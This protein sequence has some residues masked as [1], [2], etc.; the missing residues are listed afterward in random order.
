MER[1]QHAAAQ[2]DDRRE[3]H[4]HRG[5]GNPQQSHAHKQRGDDGCRKDLKHA[6]EVK[7]EMTR[8]TDIND[9]H[10]TA[11]LKTIFYFALFWPMVDI[12]ASLALGLVIWYGGLSALGGG[13]TVGILIAFIQ[14]ARRFFEP[15]RVNRILTISLYDLSLAASRSGV[16]C[17][18]SNS[19]PPRLLGGRRGMG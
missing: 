15:I 18:E 7:E 10:R 1:A 12:V 2:E 5:H 14:Y 13:L 3:Q 11:Y 8:F 16:P 9:D 4:R 6:L 17:A 19:V